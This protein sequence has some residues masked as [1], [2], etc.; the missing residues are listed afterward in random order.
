MT[1]RQLGALALIV[2]GALV[3]VSDLGPAS[4]RRDPAMIA[5]PYSYLLGASTDL[6]PSRNGDAQVT[7]ALRSQP[8]EV[9]NWA[10]GQGLSVRW[11]PGHNWAVLEG[12]AAN[13]ADA[14]DVD[15]HDYRG[16]RGQVF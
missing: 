6:G 7:V 13:L 10:E 16:R 11:R 4:T 2:A 1:T 15:V 5:G 12:A 9:F 8:D 3:F 14:F